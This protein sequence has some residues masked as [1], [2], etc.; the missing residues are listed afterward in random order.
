[1]DANL[2]AKLIKK[3]SIVLIFLCCLGAPPSWAA[4][5]ELSLEEAQEL[6]LKNSRDLQ[7]AHHDVEAQ[8]NV[9]KRAISNFFPELSLVTKAGTRHDRIA[10][11]GEKEIPSVS[12]DRNI[13]DAQLQLSQSLFSGFRDVSTLRGAKAKL[14]IQQQLETAK[15]LEKRQAVS[16]VYFLLQLKIKEKALEEKQSLVFEQRVKE[17]R[18]KMGSGR[19][20]EL[21]FLEAQYALEKQRPV[22]KSLDADIEQ[23]TLELC[24]MTGLPLDDVLVPIDT[25][26]GAAYLANELVLPE[27]SSAMDFAFKNNSQVLQL[28]GDREEL[29]SSIRLITA[30]HLPQLTLNA[31]SGIQSNRK[32]EI[33]SSRSR[34][35]GFEV[36]FTLPL[37]SGLSSFPTRREGL[38]RLSSVREKRSLM[39]EKLFDQ[40]RDLYR[41][42]EVNKNLLDSLKL[43]VKIAQD[44]V[45]KAELLYSAGRVTFSDVLENYSDHL[46]ANKALLRAA[47]D[48]VLLTGKFK[49]LMGEASIGKQS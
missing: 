45:K 46:E 12:R 41:Q 47:L 16:E 10:Q 28:E 11:P 37:F 20:T 43:G 1:M 25:L 32:D 6:T 31:F 27:M 9:V 17:M 21:D 22:L 7:A 29:E 18:T 33:G 39:R 23:K 48:R 19:S 44:K 34:V 2:L 36:N 14:F 3:K 13:Y 5:K 26:E 8:N 40:V 24:R 35:Y 15:I 38:A 49:I 4:R 42:W 30:E